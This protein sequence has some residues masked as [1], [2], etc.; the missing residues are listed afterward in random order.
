MFMIVIVRCCVFHL[1]LFLCE[2]VVA[3]IAG[4]AETV[5]GAAEFNMVAS[6]V[7]FLASLA[8]ST[9]FRDTIVE[10]AKQRNDELGRRVLLNI[11][12]ETYLPAL[13]AQYHVR[14]YNLFRP[15]NQNVDVSPDNV[16]DD[17]A[18]KSC[19]NVTYADQNRLYS[20]T[21]LYDIYAGYGGELSQKQ[22][23]V[24][25]T[26]YLADD[27]IVIRC[28][29]CASLIGFNGFVGSMMQ[30]VKVNGDDEESE[31]DAIIRMVRRE[32]REVT[33]SSNLFYDLSNFTHRNTVGQTSATLLGFVSALVSNSQ[34][35]KQSLSLSQSIQSH[36]TGCHNQTTLGL[37]GK[38]HHSHG[39]S[40]LI[41]ELSHHGYVSS[42][43]EVLRFRKSAAAFVQTNG[44]DLHQTMGLERRV[45]VIFGWMDNLDL[46]I[47][48]PNGRR[49]TTLWHTNFSNRIRAASSRQAV[50][51]RACHH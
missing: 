36:I 40:E 33:K 24:K 23:R 44:V 34:I 28:D 2:C 4:C 25:L 7:A 8:F 32:A 9:T 41:K 45:G 22:M 10:I 29:G 20:H 35:S 30:L 37:A 12:E 47:H 16:V 27:I 13:D 1:V 6:T 3:R 31:I 51:G 49:N 14:C 17:A 15:V 43:D 39:S 5:L 38:I 46:Q 42:Y 48:T 19:I 50:H 26:D 21:E 18:L 11:G